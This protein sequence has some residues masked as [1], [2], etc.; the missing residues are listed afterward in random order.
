MWSPETRLVPIARP[1]Y[2]NDIII[3]TIERSYCLFGT[4]ILAELLHD[5]IGFLPRSA[6][7]NLDKGFRKQLVEENITTDQYVV[8]SG[9]EDLGSSIQQTLAESCAIKASNLNVMIKR[10]KTDGLVESAKSA[11]R[12]SAPGARDAITLTNRGREIVVRRRKLEASV[13]QEFLKGLTSAE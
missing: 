7:Q 6:Y 12:R 8:L 11:D 2:H 10:T 3:I 9:L 13:T 5:K 1:I 4:P